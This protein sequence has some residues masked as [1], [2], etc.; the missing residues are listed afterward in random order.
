VKISFI[1]LGKL[2][3]PCAEA[4]AQK[5]HTVSGYDVRQVRSDLIQVKDTIAEA[6][7]G[8]DIVFVAVPTPHDP[9]YD[10]RA[11]T[12]HLEPKDFSYKIVK[13]V[14]EEANRFMTKDQLLV[15]ISTVLPGTTRREFVPLVT[16]TRFVYNPYLIAMG[17]VAWDMINPEMVMIGTEDGSATTDARE[18]V[19]FYQSVMENNPRYEIGTWD[20]CECIKVFYN[21]FISTKIGLVNMMQDVAQKQGNINVDVVTRALAKSTMRIISKAYMKAGMG[22]GGACHPRDNIAL[23][24]MAKEL[25]LGY[26]IFDSVM[27]AREKQAENMAIEILK[28]GNKIQF[29]SDSYKP[30]VDY[31]DGSYSLLVQHYVKQHGG[32]IVHKHPNIYVLVHEGDKVPEGVAVFDPWRSYKGPNVVYYGNTRKDKGIICE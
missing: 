23:R 12:A 11:P 17:T 18:L 30:G 6:V 21:T 5:G 20:E 25:G 14:L 13:D 10:G 1:G 2:G 3:L 4:V 29:S 28:Y 32:F 19:K 26:D 8:Q 22:D 15:L 27:N 31:V 7:A 9:A 24:Y 16:N